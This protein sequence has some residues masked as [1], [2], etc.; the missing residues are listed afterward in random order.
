MCDLF[1]Q[2]GLC[3]RT[4]G[5]LVNRGADALCKGRI[6]ITHFLFSY[7]LPVFVLLRLFLEEMTQCKINRHIH[8]YGKHLPWMKK[9]K[10]WRRE[11][12]EKKKKLMDVRGMSQSTHLRGGDGRQ[13]LK[14]G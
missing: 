12:R 6:S 9:K 10:S 2:P 4:P 8:N 14:P 3:D 13:R 5:F 7:T 1:P 11:V